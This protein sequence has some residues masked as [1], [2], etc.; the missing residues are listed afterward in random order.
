MNVLSE[1]ELQQFYVD[2]YIV[3]RSVVSLDK[4]KCALRMINSAIGQGKQVG[5]F[6]KI[7]VP[8]LSTNQQLLSLYNDSSVLS[9]VESLI[10]KH[11][12][13]MAGQVALRFPGALCQ[14]D[15]EFGD[16]IPAPWWNQCWHVDGFFSP[17][18]NL[19]PKGEIHN[20]TCL[21]GILL[22]DVTSEF[23]GNL[24][25][26]PGSHRSLELYFNKYGFDK[27]K[28]DGL[29]SL[30]P[31]IPIAINPIQI[32]GKA[33][34]VVL[35]HYQ[36]A[37]TIAPN[38]SENIRYAVYF[39]A[40]KRQDSMHHPEPMLDIWKDWDVFSDWKNKKDIQDKIK[41]EMELRCRNDSI[42]KAPLY[43]DSKAKL[44]FIE[45]QKM[46]EQA[47]EIRK[48][49]KKYF[50]QHNWNE[51]LKYYKQ[52]DDLQE[53]NFMND[54][55]SLFQAAICYTHAPAANTSEWKRGEIILQNAIKIAPRLAGCW[56]LMAQNQL[57]QKNYSQVINAVDKFFECPAQIPKEKDYSPIRDI[58]LSLWSALNESKNFTIDLYDNY[59]RK[60]FSVY[61]S[62]KETIDSIRKQQ[63]YQQRW[64]AAMKVFMTFHSFPQAATMFLE[65]VKEK[66]IFF[67]L[68]FNHFEN[69]FFIF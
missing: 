30:I 26:F 24:T 49:A 53:R 56:S 57:K 52:L 41:I 59:E 60:A 32:T 63:S 47:I 23:S 43:P 31:D 42:T 44:S 34:D 21:V 64:D 4:I 55:E 38:I 3:L 2:G 65:L 1:K 8:H 39:R 28:K 51:S 20:F 66:V 50:Q 9:I 16:I 17:G 35:C 45:E 48:E 18:N 40:N 69:L 68:F 62:E 37:H 25:V 27:V 13:I 19:I 33:G 10:G 15:C 7:D 6:G 12:P 46:R 67:V 54:F 61:P 36:L 29:D 22:Q 11:F 58:L 14:G 5:D